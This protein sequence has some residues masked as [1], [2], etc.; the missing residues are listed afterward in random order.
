MPLYRLHPLFQTDTSV[1]QDASELCP[2]VHQPGARRSS[3][4][5]TATPGTSPV[6]PGT[7]PKATG[8]WNCRSPPAE[9]PSAPAQGQN[10]PLVP[11]RL[12][13]K[14]LEQRALRKPGVG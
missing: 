10:L 6:N 11:G 5:V 13:G 9:P 8:A 7:S 12:G 4:L 2:Q 3:A 1:T 14:Q